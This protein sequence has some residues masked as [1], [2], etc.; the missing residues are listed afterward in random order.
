MMELY[1]DGGCEP[2]PGL[3]AWAWVRVDGSVTV[4]D[5]GSEPDTTNNRMELR[6]V[7]E[8]LNALPT[9]GIRVVVYSD[10]RY[11]IDGASKWVHNWKRRDWRTKTKQPVKNQDL[12][13]ALDTASSRHVVTWRW[14]KGHAGVAFNER[15]DELTMRTIVMSR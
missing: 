12:W 6:A 10:S 14:C 7:I 1:T 11:V 13:M 4:E 9:S 3:G 15:C 2:N 5:C 8:G